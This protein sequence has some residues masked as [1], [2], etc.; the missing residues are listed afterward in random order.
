MN[1]TTSAND[2]VIVSYRRTPFGRAKK[3]VFAEE[4]PE[5][6]AAAAV[7]GALVDLGSEV[8]SLLEDSYYGCAVPEGTQGDNIARRVNVMLGHDFLPG[9]TVNR[10]CASSL[11]ALAMASQAIRAGEGSAYLAA[12]VEST[13]SAPP[14]V[15]APHPVFTES[16]RRAKRAFELHEEWTNPREFGLS[17]DVS[18]PMGM[19]AEFVAG[20]TKT[21]RQDQDEWAFVSQSRARQCAE[22]GL[23]KQEIVKYTTKSGNVVEI[24]ECPRPETTL[25]GLASLNPVFRDNGTVTAGNASPLN[26]G[27]SSMVVMSAA[28]ANDLGIKPQARILGSA[29]TALS[30]E[31]MGLGPVEASRKLLKRFGM[32]IDDID[33]IELNEAF[34]AQVVPTIR[35][36]KADPERVNPFGGAIAMGHPFGATGIRLVGSAINALKHRDGTLGLATL[37]VGGGQ[38]M[39]LLIE[40]LD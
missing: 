3:G 22:A 31:I 20:L 12:G 34:A 23:L 26:D 39:A 25:E 15:N 17:P 33:V 7:A 30:P 2:S 38:G 1:F 13:S 28:A 8:L 5:D 37:C 21:S 40:R 18:I 35:M 6:L 27:A 24:D 10:F 4:R 19:T 32:A 14:V 29:A 16:A 36:L 9:V 11:Q